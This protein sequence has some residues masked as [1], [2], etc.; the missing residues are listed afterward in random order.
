[1]RPT[2]YFG[3]RYP[4]W[5]EED[6]ILSQALILDEDARCKGCGHYADE[7]HDPDMDGWYEVETETCH[8]CAAR[9]RE[10]AGR[11]GDP[12]PGEII[13]VTNTKPT[14]SKVSA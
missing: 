13:Y 9:D 14:D 6:R 10:S 5:C 11:T 3:L 12:A 4:S 2:E 1:M 7:S 8:A